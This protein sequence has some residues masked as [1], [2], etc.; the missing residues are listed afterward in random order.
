[1]RDNV[2]VSYETAQSE[3]SAAANP[4][5]WVPPV[6]ISR[7]PVTGSRSYPPDDRVL[8]TVEVAAVVATGDDE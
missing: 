2:A 3:W 6:S 4:V 7:F 5:T 1:M 8:G